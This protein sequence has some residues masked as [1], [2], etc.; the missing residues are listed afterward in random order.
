MSIRRL[1][2]QP[3][4][5]YP[6]VKTV[7]SYHNEVI[8]LGDPVAVNGLLQQLSSTEYLTDRDTTVTQWTVFL[9]AGTAV[10]PQ[11][12]VVYMGQ[13]FQVTGLPEM[14]WNPR[15]QKVSHIEAKLTEVS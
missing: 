11:S 4:T 7:D 9:P 12:Q 13:T 5:V 3:L 8:G 6:A 15:S 14:V 10:D 2:N 1:L